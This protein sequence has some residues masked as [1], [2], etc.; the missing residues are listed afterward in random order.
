MRSADPSAPGASLQLDD[1][2]VSFVS[3]L[4]TSLNYNGL[5]SGAD[6]AHAVVRARN[7][8]SEPEI[9]QLRA[10]L[11]ELSKKLDGVAAM[12]TP[13]EPVL[14]GLRAELRD[15]NARFNDLIPNFGAF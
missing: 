5:I 2:E 4:V 3:Q 14:S 15:L 10:K 7:L 6:A 11:D 13:S 8:A 1:H 12:V 9:V